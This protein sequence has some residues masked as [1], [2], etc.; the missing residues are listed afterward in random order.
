[1]K[2]GLYILAA[3]MLFSCISAGGKTTVKVAERHILVN[4]KPYLI[5]GICYHP[6]PKG[7]KT[8]DFGT[9]TRDLALMTEAGVNTIRVY[10]PID[11][12]AVLDE[13]H[14]AGF[15][16]IIGIG[17]DQGGCYDIRSGSFIDY[18]NA[19]KDHPAVLM[20]ELGNECNFHPEVFDGDL[21]K[22]YEALNRSAEMI[23]QND[24]AHPVTTAHGE[25]PDDT[26]LAACPNVDVWGMNVYRWD[27]PEDIFKEWALV[28]SKPMYLAEAG[29]DSYMTAAGLGYEQGPNQRAQADANGKILDAV[30]SHQDICS[31]VALF[32]FSDEWWKAGSPDT[33]DAG[34]E[35][36][37][38]GGV[39]YDG[40]ANEDYWGIVDVDGNRK[41][42][43]AV[44]KEKYNAF[45]NEKEVAEE[46]VKEST[47]D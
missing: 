37:W 35:A 25:L 5:K 44:V 21:G 17:Y 22:W 42:T 16:L 32:A 29:A 45:P 26:A 31:G 34:D 18:V 40:A 39:P 20:W 12:R 7:K 28:S 4:G 15:K 14:A 47:S 9:L 6:V 33:Q 46:P 11:D 27:H 3:A 30:F 41:L 19:Y 8:R 36:A 23:H 2:K 38:S 13:I 10:S 43:F 24:P 1:M